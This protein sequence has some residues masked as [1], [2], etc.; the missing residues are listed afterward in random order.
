MAAKTSSVL[1]TLL[2]NATHPGSYNSD[3]PADSSAAN[4][5]ASALSSVNLDSNVVDFR[6]LPGNTAAPA[7]V[8]NSDPNVVNL[9]GTAST[10]PAS[11]KSQI[12]AVF[13]NPAPASAPPAARVT[14]ADVSAIFDKH[15]PDPNATMKA[16]F[17]LNNKSK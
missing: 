12:D 6:G 8:P 11:L 7:T 1:A 16:I 15:V 13:G 2:G 14:P 9:S 3:S 10:S 5:N 17:D 4:P